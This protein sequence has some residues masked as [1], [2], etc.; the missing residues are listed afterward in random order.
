M[1]ERQDL[2]AGGFSSW[3]RLTRSAQ[4]QECGVEVPC[5]ECTACCTSSYFIHVGPTETETLARIPSELLFPAPGLPEGNVLLGYDKHGRCPML[6]DGRCSIYE[7]RPLTCRTYDCRVF[8]A[9][10]I[11][12]DRAPITERAR[13]WRFGYSTSDDRRRHA[14]VRAAARFL[15]ERAECFP[16]GAVP[17]NPAQVAILA[18]K[19]YKVFLECTDGSSEKGRMPADSAVADAVVKANEEFEARRETRGTLPTRNGCR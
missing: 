11:A 13:R 5:G 18:I 6:I 16:G 9:A 4:V 17:D 14:A 10:G 3:L 12:A 2:P 19:I 15:R 1:S 8:A 7:D